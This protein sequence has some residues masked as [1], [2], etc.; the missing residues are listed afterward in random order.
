VVEVFCEGEQLS[1]GLLSSDGLGVPPDSFTLQIV[2]EIEITVPPIGT[3]V[4]G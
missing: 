4:V 3:F 2:D 1:A